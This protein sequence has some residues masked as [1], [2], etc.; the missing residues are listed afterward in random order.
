MMNLKYFFYNFVTT[1]PIHKILGRLKNCCFVYFAVNGL[2]KV[3]E[4]LLFQCNLGDFIFL[5]LTFGIL[6][7]F[8]KS[9]FFKIGVQP[10]FPLL[11]SHPEPTCQRPY[12]SA[13]PPC[14]S[15]AYSLASWPVRVAAPW[16]R[17]DDGVRKPSRRLPSASRSP[18][19]FL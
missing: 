14:L 12:P 15:R 13:A 2:G 10:A 1:N 4:C 9:P 6:F 17:P 5:L 11:P 16:R 8:R 19:Y 18:L 7:Y 3:F